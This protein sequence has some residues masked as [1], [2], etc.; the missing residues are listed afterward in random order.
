MTASAFDLTGRVALVTGAS[1]GIGHRLALELAKAGAKV[2][3]AA[4]R[5]DRLEALVAEI[6]AAGGTALAVAMDVEDEASVA[7]GYEAIKAALGPVDTVYANAGMSIEGLAL[8]LP[9]DAFD[10]IMAVNVRGVFITA[11]EGARRMIK[12]GSRDTRRGRIVLVA[13]I[14]AHTV[15]PGLTAYCTSKAAVAMMGKSLAREWARQG[16]NVNVICPG[17]L[18]TELNS[19]WFSSEGGKKHVQSF[20]RRRLMREGDLDPILLYLGADVSEA[21]TGSV[22]TVDDGQSL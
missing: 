10:K 2:A 17:Y 19:D 14:G 22:F 12:A 13:S 7:A 11:R 8:D 21:T 4:R 5:T 20:P 6:E 16:I 15:L 9:A 3:A 18:E 1:S